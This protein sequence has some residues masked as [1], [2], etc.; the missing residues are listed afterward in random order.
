MDP[1][2]APSYST[3]VFPRG[4]DLL[5]IQA[6]PV[7][8]HDDGYEGHDDPGAACMEDSLPFLFGATFLLRF[9]ML[10]WRP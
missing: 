2:N 8:L 6:N 7:F 9:H 3:P 4:I 1:E 10:Y 5:L